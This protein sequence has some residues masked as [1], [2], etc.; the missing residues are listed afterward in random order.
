MLNH[1]FRWLSCLAMFFFCL[2]S[3][4]QL[5]ILSISFLDPDDT[6]YSFLRLT[7]C[8]I[9]CS[10]DGNH[11]IVWQR[12]WIHWKGPQK[13]YV[14]C[15]C[16]TLVYLVYICHCLYCMTWS[17]ALHYEQGYSVAKICLLL[18][19]KKT[20][21]YKTLQHHCAFGIAFDPHSQWWGVCH[22]HLTTTDHSF[23]HALLNQNHTIYLDEIQ[24]QLLSCHGVKASITTLYRTLQWL[25]FT[26]KDVS[27]KELECNEWDWV[28]FMN[29]I[30]ELVPNPDMLM[31]GDEV[32]KDERTSNRHTGWSH[33]G[34]R[35]VQ[36]KCFVQGKRFSI[37]P[38][39]TLD[40]IIAHDIIE[41]SVTSEKFHEFL[42]ELVV[43]ICFPL[44]MYTHEV[45]S[46]SHWLT[47]TQGHVVFWFSTIVESTMLKRYGSLLKMKPVYHHLVYECSCH[48]L[49]WKL[50][51]LPPYLPDY[52]PIEQA[53]SSIKAFLQTNWQDKSLGLINWACHNI[54]PLD[55]SKL[56]DTLSSIHLH[57]SRMSQSSCNLEQK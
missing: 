31:F 11:S 28:I 14:H 39:I 33:Q 30:M 41:G 47:P 3:F 48:A 27:S 21:V 24:E 40:G 43:C 6:F 26:H 44:C 38:I 9:S 18:N 51:F 19:I 23:I 13:F 54:T 10:F 46:R 36:R 4:F 52:N 42:H 37:L 7:Y 53:F 25:H 1:Y 50:I 16:E 12:S 34:S 8:F 17:P 22:R 20:L 35:C 49:E 56:P 57:I 45:K 15:E 5:L 32:H 55:T 2:I 29:W